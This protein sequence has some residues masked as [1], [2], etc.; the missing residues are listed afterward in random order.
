MDTQLFLDAIKLALETP[1]DTLLER[2]GALLLEAHA[3]ANTASAVGDTSVGNDPAIVRVE[4]VEA[5]P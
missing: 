4:N 1:D 5:D 3:A 2:L